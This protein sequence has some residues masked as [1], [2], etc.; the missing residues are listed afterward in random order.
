MQRRLLVFLIVVALAIV[1]VPAFTQSG[2]L[3]QDGG[4]EGA[5]TNRGRADL[6]VPAP[7]GVWFTESPRTE[8]WM[9]QPP[10]AFPHNGPDPNPVAGAHAFNFNK[11]YATYTAAIYQQVAVPQGSNVTGSAY[12]QQKTCNPAPNTPTCGSSAESGAY[13]RVCIDPNGGTN[14]FDSDVICSANATPHDR[15]DLISVSATTTGPTA[16]IFL[17]NTQAWPAQLNTAYW[18]EA[19]LTIG[20]AGGT[21]PGVPGVP[22]ATAVPTAPPFASFVQPQPPQADGSIVHIVQPGDTMDAIGYAYGVSRQDILDLNG[23]TSGR[24]IFAGQELLIK[25]ASEDA[26]APANQVAAAPTSAVPAP[27]ETQT[28]PV[29]AAAT[30]TNPMA[31]MRIRPDGA[32]I[33][34]VQPGDTLAALAPV[35]GATADDLAALNGIAPDAVLTPGSEL[36]VQPPVTTGQAGTPVPT[37]AAPAPATPAPVS[38]GLSPDD[39]PA[40]PIVSITSGGVLPAIDPAA[41]PAQVCVLMFEDANQNRLQ[42]AGEALLPGGAIVLTLDGVPAGEYV[43]TGSGEPFCFSDLP[44]GNYLAQ[45]QAP[46]GYGLTTPQQLLLQPAQGWTINVGFGAAQGVQPPAIPPADASGAPASGQPAT[47][48]APDNPLGSNLGLVAFGLAAVA[49]VVGSVMATVLRGR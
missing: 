31:F 32:V 15:W 8:A 28:G 2:N 38:P 43:T 24:F 29:V 27:V 47:G 42:E 10:V 17:F 49:G 25:P 12:G 37:E 20:G 3:L 11:G 13:M 18:D 46:A 48:L 4:M 30:V 9:N 21:A 22:A 35:I 23:L 7:W 41:S 14:P 44:A 26:P 16:T 5:F 45:A 40:A 1:A 39:A 34:T 19:S 36:I 6:N 33:Y